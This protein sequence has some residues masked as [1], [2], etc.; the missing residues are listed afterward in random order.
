MAAIAIQALTKRYG[1]LVASAISTSP[2]RAGRSSDSWASTAPGRAPRFAS[3]S[4]SSGRR[5]DARPSLDTTAS[6]TAWRRARGRLP[7][8]R[9]GILRGHDRRRRARRDRATERQRRGPRVSPR[10]AERLELSAPDLRPSHPRLQHRHETE[11]GD[12]AG[13]SIGPADARARRADRGARSADAGGVLR[14]ARRRPPPRPHRLHVVAR[15]V[16]GRACLR[17]HCGDSPGPL[18]L[19]SPVDEL[20]RIAA[21]RVR[22][23]FDAAVPPPP[24]LPEGCELV[25]PRPP[26]GSCVCA[27]R[28]A[29]CWRGWRAWRCG[30]GSPR[31]AA[32]RSPQAVLPRRQ[33]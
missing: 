1:R 12:R 30:P 6:A 2:S 21:R 22:V 8:R 5:Q 26:H 7:A 11:A 28:S 17:S 31:G 24:A 27:G 20:R 3:C 4:T 19:L 13:V 33:T 14:A 29:R 25:E 15:P 23:I 10:A 18:V 9:A 32:R 16:R